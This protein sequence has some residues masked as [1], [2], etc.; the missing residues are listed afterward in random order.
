LHTALAADAEVVA[1]GLPGPAFARHM[2]VVDPPDHSRL[3]RLVASA[4]SVPR[5]EGLGPRV[6]R[7]IDDLLD[8]IAADAPDSRV[9]LVASFA[10]PLPFTVICEL[11]GVPQADRT[12]L[13]RALTALLTP[14][15]TPERIRT[16]ETGIRRCRRNARLAR[17]DQTERPRR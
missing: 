16:R 2:L 10:F 17:P 14:T 4:F 15:S 5:I 12:P 11:L 13:R 7:V 1:E 3:R 9:D 8:D 6:Q